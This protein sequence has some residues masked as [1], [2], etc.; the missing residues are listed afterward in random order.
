VES[1]H[2]GRGQEL[3]PSGG[4]CAD[5]EC[6]LQEI[7]L[8]KS[9]HPVRAEDIVAITKNK[10][11]AQTDLANHEIVTLATYLAGG[12]SN[13]ANTEDIAIKASEIAPGRFAW[14]KYKE[15]ININTVRKRLW[16]AT[17][18]EKG[19]Y[20]MGSE[21]SGWLLTQ[22]GLK[23]CKNSLRTLKLST[24]FTRR[25]SKQEQGWIKH[26]RLRLLAEPAYVKFSA[27]SAGEISAIEAE[28][29]FRVDDYVTG[30][31]RKTKV[32]RSIAAFDSDPL[33]AEAT[34]HIAALVRKK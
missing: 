16:D 32:Q 1:S 6:K 8:S 7:L 28:R 17:K 18:P 33:L 15:Q 34:R 26:E 29:F 24:S 31:A 5:L 25:H 12:R 13:Y 10:K 27:G 11:K 3:R 20:L 9:A 23:F 19:G 22:A 21:R 14:R 4:Q 2:L 30:S